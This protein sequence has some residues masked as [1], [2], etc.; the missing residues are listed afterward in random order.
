MDVKEYKKEITVIF[1]RYSRRGYVDY[2]A[3]SRLCS[4]LC[5][6]LQHASNE[7]SGKEL[8]DVACRAFIKWGKTDKDDSD[9]DTQVFMGEIMTIWDV[10][11]ECNQQEISHEKMLQWF[12]KT[13]NGSVFDYM[14]EY[15]YEF[16]ISH[17]K[18]IELLQIKFDFIQAK[19]QE[20][21]EQLPEHSYFQYEI[22]RFQIY[23]LQIMGERKD[24]IESIR[25]FAGKLNSD[26][27]K[28]KLAEIEMEYGN[29]D[30]AIEIYQLLAVKEDSNSWRKNQYRM[31][32]KDI[33]KTQGQTEKY[34]QEL[35]SL[36]YHEIGNRALY[37]EYRAYFAPEKWQEERELL[38]AGL[39]IGDS[40][41]NAWY[42]M[43]GRYDLIMDNIEA[44]TN[45]MYLQEYEKEL[46]KRYP[47]RCLTVLAN[48]ADWQAAHSSKRSQYRHIARYLKWMT[49]Y[50]G[51][52]E[53]AAQL[54]EKY[55]AQYPRRR[56]MLD[57]LDGF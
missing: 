11:H 6:L 23:C 14:E 56:A 28:E 15:L 42:E 18:E 4:D 51:G 27:A 44:S 33:Y 3:C 38:F 30:R 20:K 24:S 22:E 32:L 53:M 1:N 25:K 36:V 19:I 46:R 43:E 47:E 26:S 9:G 52:F 50:P 34:F 35:K 8:F 16:M 41:A 57:E 10:L 17:F 49:A 39:K 37:E 21:K 45:T 48:A 40:R 31:I 54:A 13:L 5:D 12:M 2:W 7:L 55:R 29:L